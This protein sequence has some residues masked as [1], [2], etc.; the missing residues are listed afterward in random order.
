M[1][2]NPREAD[3][4]ERNAEPHIAPSGEMVTGRAF[5]ILDEIAI[6]LL[7]IRLALVEAVGEVDLRFDEFDE[8]LQS[9]E[10]LVHD[11]VKAVG[12]LLLDAELDPRWGYQ[13]SRPKAVLAR[14]YAATARGTSRVIPPPSTVDVFDDIVEAAAGERDN[15]D[16][17][18]RPPCA[19]TVR[20]GSRQCSKWVLYLGGGAWASGCHSHASDDERRR[21]SEYRST[22]A[23]RA[24]V[25]DAQV[26]LIRHTGARIVGDWLDRRHQPD[27][28]YNAV[29]ARRPCSDEP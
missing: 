11:A 15:P 18:S 25:T 7:E 21:Y 10:W 4:A 1:D 28:L 26:E 19:A 16:W 12:L 22:I 27:S 23:D 8:P 29:H 3:D 20:D 13:A 14:H 24:A 5:Q 2:S 17:K 9:L 6:R